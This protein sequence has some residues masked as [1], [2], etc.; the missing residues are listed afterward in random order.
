MDC[1]STLSADDLIP[2]TRRNLELVFGIVRDRR[3]DLTQEERD[4]FV[5]AGAVRLKVRKATINVARNTGVWPSATAAYA[6]ADPRTIRRRVRL[7]HGNHRTIQK[8]APATTARLKPDT[9][10]R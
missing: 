5:E 7:L 4:W 8:A 2:V 9:T 3:D 10:T 1:Y 6:S